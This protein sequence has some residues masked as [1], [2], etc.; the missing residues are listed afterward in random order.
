MLFPFSRL[1]TLN[2]LPCSPFLH[3]LLTTSKCR[4]SGF[5][6]EGFGLRAADGLTSSVLYL[7]GQVL[8]SLIFVIHLVVVWDS[9]SKDVV[10]SEIPVGPLA[11]WC[12]FLALSM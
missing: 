8:P 6:V 12:E 1:S 10:Q 3:Q 4:V 11:A 9:A 2:L 7:Y 5:W